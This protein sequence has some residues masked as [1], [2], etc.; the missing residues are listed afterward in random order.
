MALFLSSPTFSIFFYLGN[1]FH[2]FFITSQIILAKVSSSIQGVFSGAVQCSGGSH[3]PQFLHPHHYKCP[4]L[5]I[6][7]S[8]HPSP[9]PVPLLASQTIDVSPVLAAHDLLSCS[10]LS[11]SRTFFCLLFLYFFLAFTQHFPILL[12]VPTSKL[13]KGD[14]ACE[15]FSNFHL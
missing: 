1:E 13:P 7:S 10:P 5:D 4:S 3:S 12:T 9:F 15:V 2:F 8:C 11:F 14:F 6:S